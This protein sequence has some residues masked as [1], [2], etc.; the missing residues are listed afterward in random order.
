M[1][2]RPLD[3]AS[4]RGYDRKPRG[5]HVWQAWDANLRVDE[6]GRPVPDALEEVGEAVA[7]V[8][9]TRKSDGSDVSN[10]LGRIRARHVC[11]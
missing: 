9:K 10:P 8:L 4:F 11:A 6:H 1:L 7:K 5:E 3:R 2:D